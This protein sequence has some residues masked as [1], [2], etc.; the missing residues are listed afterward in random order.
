LTF[1]LG[2]Q[3]TTSRDILKIACVSRI[4]V[5]NNKVV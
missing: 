4:T 2:Y 1:I 3:Q 5:N